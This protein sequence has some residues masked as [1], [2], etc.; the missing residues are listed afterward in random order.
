MRSIQITED[1]HVYSKWLKSELYRVKTD[2][3]TSEIELVENPNLQNLEDNVARKNLLWNK[4]G[5]S[6]ILSPLPQNITWHEVVIEVDDI[7]KMYILPVFDWFMDTG[8]TFKLKDTTD[9]LAPNRGYNIRPDLRGSVVHHQK[10]EEM[11][12]SENNNYSDIVIISSGLT[13]KPYTI[14]D[15]THRSTFLYKNNNLTGTKAFLGIA[16]DLSSYIWSIERSSMN[17]DLRELNQL[18]DNGLLW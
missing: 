16:H 1:H 13:D 10:I 18:A 8:R 4:Y 3:S 5:R 11:S 14:I 17:N 15:G 7:E 6:A 9:N 2:L 12:I